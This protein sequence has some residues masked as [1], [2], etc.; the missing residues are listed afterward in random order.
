[1]NVSSDTH[2][3]YGTMMSRTSQQAMLSRRPGLRPMV[4][5]RSTYPGAGTYVGHWL[6]DNISVSQ[7]QINVPSIH[8]Y[9][10][11]LTYHLRLGIST[12]SQFDISCNLFLS[13]KYQW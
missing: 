9:Q 4:I 2:N 11:T 6:G 1:M 3:L 13:F 7:S 8:H 12:L 5:T 10:F